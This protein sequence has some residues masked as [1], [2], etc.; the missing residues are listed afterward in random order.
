MSVSVQDAAARLLDARLGHHLVAPPS[1]T[2]IELSL[3]NAYA[4]QDALGAK[5]ARRGERPI[6][7][8][9]AATS[10]TGQAVMGVSEPAYG[11][12]PSQEHASGAELSVRGFVDLRIEAEVAF[13]MGSDLAGPGVT[14]TDALS[15]VSSALPAFEVL[16]FI[17]S[18]TPR[19]ADYVANSIHGQAV[20]LGKPLAPLHGLDLALEE[21]LLENNGE[22][23]D[24]YRASNVMGNPLNALAWLANQLGS[25]GLQLKRGDLIISGGI[26]KLLRPK[27]GDLITAT[28]T[29]LGSVAIEVVP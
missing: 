28:F 6:G 16:D 1:E 2:D 9:L 7:W 19:A 5:L 3:S 8:K 27:A 14:A 10:P 29:H 21:V 22:V 18:G 11:F 23:V 4:I 17:Y 12:L 13:R 20:V 24:T 26:S 15:A 25:R